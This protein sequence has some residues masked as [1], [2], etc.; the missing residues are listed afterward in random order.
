MRF[1]RFTRCSFWSAMAFPSAQ[2]DSISNTSD[3]DFGIRANLTYSRLT[4]LLGL[5]QEDCLFYT[6]EG[7]AHPRPCWNLLMLLTLLTLLTHLSSCNGWGLDAIA[8]SVHFYFYF[9]LRF[10]VFKHITRVHFWVDYFVCLNLKF[11]SCVYVQNSSWLGDISSHCMQLQAR[12]SSMYWTECFRRSSYCP[13]RLVV[14]IRSTRSN[15][16]C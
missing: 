8:T 11:I 16:L 7:R 9:Y 6:C 13:L 4:S 12:S 1:G 15:R 10:G 3:E 5:S 2:Q 14:I